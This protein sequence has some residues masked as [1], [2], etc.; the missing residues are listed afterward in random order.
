MVS[1]NV[2]DK[3]IN[4]V[5]TLHYQITCVARSVSQTV[6]VL[7]MLSSKIAD[8]CNKTSGGRQ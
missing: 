2:A 6:P 5:F 7:S 8:M 1:S 4:M 3:L